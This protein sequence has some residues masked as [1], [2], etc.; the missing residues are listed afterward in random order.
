[1]ASLRRREEQIRRLIGERLLQNGLYIMGT[2]V[3]TSVFGLV[4]WI[5]ATH[6]LRSEEV[7]RGAA[8]LSAVLLVSV[9]TNFGVG[10]LYIS[11]LHSRADGH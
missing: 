6:D 1:V 11:R 7:G 2:T 5:V 4:Y 9:F 10:Q 3:V 8:L